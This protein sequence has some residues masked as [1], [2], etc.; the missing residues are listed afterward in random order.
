MSDNPSNKLPETEP[1]A[2][3]AQIAAE[4][5]AAR[6]T[7]HDIFAGI[8]D[9]LL[10]RVLA[11]E[12]TADEM[13]QVNATAASNPELRLA[14]DTLRLVI[15]DGDDS[16]IGNDQI[17]TAPRSL[18]AVPATQV[19]DTGGDLAVEWHQVQAELEKCRT[20]Q[21][22]SWQDID[23]RKLARYVAGECSISEQQSVKSDLRTNSKLRDA[24]STTRTVLSEAEKSASIR[25][26]TDPIVIAVPEPK[27]PF[28]KYLRQQFMGFL[29]EATIATAAAAVLFVVISWQ[30]GETLWHPDSPNTQFAARLPMPKS[31]DVAAGG[32]EQVS[33]NDRSPM[34]VAHTVAKPFHD[35]NEIRG[36]IFAER[37]KPVL[38]PVHETAER[39]EV[40]TG[41]LFDQPGKFAQIK[42]RI[43][44]VTTRYVNETV[45]R[46]EAFRQSMTIDKF[47][48][49]VDSP[50]ALDGRDLTQLL[51][52]DDLICRY[53]AISAIRNNNVDVTVKSLQAAGM[54][55]RAAYLQQTG[56]LLVGADDLEHS[57]YLLSQLAL[58]ALDS[59]SANAH[60]AGIYVL[61][62]LLQ[63]R[64]IIFSDDSQSDIANEPSDR[65]MN[66]NGSQSHVNF[67]ANSGGRLMKKLIEFQT[68]K[69]AVVR[70][71]AVYL[72]GEIG[73]PAAA[74]ADVLRN[75]F[76]ECNDLV[77]RRWIAF[78][79]GQIGAASRPA[80]PELLDA[81][82]ERDERI[83]SA[84]AFSIGRILE[85]APDA[86][87]RQAWI[88]VGKIAQRVSPLMPEWKNATG[89]R[90]VWSDYLLHVLTAFDSPMQDTNPEQTVPKRGAS[91]PS[92]KP[93]FLIPK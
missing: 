24:E 18:F 26:R 6:D 87:T 71:S 40:I 85:S 79:L 8:S 93:T 33:E 65:L 39:E 80:I 58:D 41:E 48:D 57:D 46:V 47:Y 62:R 69:N 30:M 53:A 89:T 66:H 55:E 13:A 2:A 9:D 84:A 23:E 37:Q 73:P 21:Q 91:A 86:Q 25:T 32:T 72:V 63:A 74:L 22:N 38:K 15:N 77:E 61:I 3:W 75:R 4:L 34:M 49:G 16:S 11:G 12:A 88:T 54:N 60:W 27:V 68:D 52:S 81:L 76:V 44:Q 28:G 90:K 5:R 59:D 70:K 20:L 92:G 19:T 43:P 14:L 10:S 45:N 36:W 67:D 31:E 78:A 64:T 17:P 83:F 35:P 56:Q 29:R 42:R 82:N 1:S 51:A 7:Q 50:L